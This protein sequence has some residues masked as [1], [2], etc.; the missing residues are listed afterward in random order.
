[1]NGLVLALAVLEFLVG[2]PG[3]RLPKLDKRTDIHADIMRMG[4]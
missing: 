2:H 4:V 1:M 3:R